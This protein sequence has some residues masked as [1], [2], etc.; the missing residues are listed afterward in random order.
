MSLPAA[1][2]PDPIAVLVL[3]WD[4]AAPAVRALVEATQAS[5][6]PLDSLLVMVPQADAPTGLHAEEYLPLPP[7]PAVALPD[8]PEP[9]T[10]PLLPGAGPLPVTSAAPKAESRRPIA[11]GIVAGP[12]PLPVLSTQPPATVKPTPLAWAAVRVVRLGSL[13]LP[14]LAAQAR[15][16]LPAPIWL[17]TAAAPAAPYAGASDLREPSVS[18]STPGDKPAT[19]TLASPA[20]PASAS[21]A[22][23]ST[24]YSLVPATTPAQANVL[25]ISAQPA[26]PRYDVTDSISQAPDLAADLAPNGADELA[27]FEVLATEALPAEDSLFNNPEATPALADW[28]AALATLRHPA[29][30]PEAAPVAK[31]APTAKPTAEPA[32]AIYP[33][34]RPAAQHY[35]APDLNFQIIQYARF[36]VPVALAEPPFAVLYA[37]AWPTWLA[38]QELRQRTG[39]PLVL[40]V[41]TLAAADDEPVETASGWIAELQRQALRRADLIL[42]ETPA[43]AQRLRH[44]LALGPDRVL[45]I[46]AAEAAAIAQALRAAQ[47][48]P[49]AT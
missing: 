10:Q 26:P 13:S 28:P 18:V 27:S 6:P 41:A 32:N 20:S 40:H 16:P 29:A 4:E 9:E 48:R 23:L 2:S 24:V 8:L 21:V 17:H 30:L 12:T 44:E 1:V 38:A 11:T 3:A 31:P 36:A 34:L 42:A 33:A 15:Q 47:P 25:P 5:A 49:A 14:Q 19:S 37:P 22:T 35:P 7:A 39:R 43:L 46:P 45:A